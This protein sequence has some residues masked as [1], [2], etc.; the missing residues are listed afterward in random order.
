[1]H[2]MPS[3]VPTDPVSVTAAASPDGAG[4]GPS[5]TLSGS[6]DLTPS[7][8]SVDVVGTFLVQP[9]TVFATPLTAVSPTAALNTTFHPTSPVARPGGS[10]CEG[11]LGVSEQAVSCSASISL[12]VSQRALKSRSKGQPLSSPMLATRPRF[13]QPPRA[14]AQRD[15]VLAR[16]WTR[17]VLHP[18]RHSASAGPLA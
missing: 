17:L 2:G 4:A 12:A 10:Y 1:M 14:S 13:R 7:I 16:D 18:P 11:V 5:L 15:S 8:F 3:L 6:Q 9:P